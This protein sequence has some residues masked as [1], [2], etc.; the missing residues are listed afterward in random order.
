M[1]DRGWVK[2]NITAKIRVKCDNGVSS[3]TRLEEGDTG[4]GVEITPILSQEK[5]ISYVPL[6]RIEEMT[7]ANRKSCCGNTK[8]G[9]NWCECR[10]KYW[11]LL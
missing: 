11:W 6:Y 3:F 9:V 1:A 7:H 5:N 10:L 8:D 4:G 2:S